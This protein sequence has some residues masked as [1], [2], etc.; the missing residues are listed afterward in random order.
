M[1]G[2]MIAFGFGLWVGGFAMGVQVG[3]WSYR[4]LM[5]RQSK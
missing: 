3:Q 1:N 2:S 5:R 4:R